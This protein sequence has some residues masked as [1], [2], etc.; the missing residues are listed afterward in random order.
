MAIRLF[1]L[2]LISEYCFQCHRALTALLYVSCVGVILL[3]AAQ[4]ASSFTSSLTTSTSASETV[5]SAVS[6][7]AGG[8]AFVAEA[9]SMSM[10]G[11]A[12]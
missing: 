7:E 3:V 11:N 10:G 5:I 6:E 4:S 9:A 8:D 1:C 2:I 12:S